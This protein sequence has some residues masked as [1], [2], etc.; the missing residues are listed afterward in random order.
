MHIA[1]LE[2]N[3]DQAT[4]VKMWLSSHHH[5]C[6]LFHNGHDFLERLLSGGVDMAVIDWELPDINGD[7]VLIQ[8]RT[9]F[10]STIPV[11]FTTLHDKEEDIVKILLLG[12][13]DYMVKPIKY[14]EMLVRIDLLG[15][16]YGDA[17]MQSK[18]VCTPYSI[19]LRNKKVFSGEA[20]IVVSRKQFELAKYFF[21]NINRLLSRDEILDNVWHTNTQITTRTVDTHVSSLRKKLNI[22]SKNG[23]NLNSVYSYGYRLEK[24]DS[25]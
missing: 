23:W 10:N 6:E 12:A 19:D 20:E 13:D 17:S 22:C 14:Q 1:V 4:L 5:S 2:D 16:R 18:L 24:V 21:C 15:R 7:E 25:P 11:I 9:N 3:L 8:L